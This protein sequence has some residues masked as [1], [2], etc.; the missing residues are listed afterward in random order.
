MLT[1]EQRAKLYSL[2]EGNTLKAKMGYHDYLVQH[3]FNEPAVE[4]DVRA[5]STADAALTSNN[6]QTTPEEFYRSLNQSRHP[7]MLTHYSVSDLAQMKLFKV[8]GHDIGYALKKWKDGSFSEIVAVHNNEPTVKGLGKALVRSSIRNGGCILDHFEGYLS[9]LY[10][11]MGFE[12]F[13]R[14]LFDPQYD[15]TGSFRAK[16]GP[17]DV[18]YRVLPR[19]K[20]KVAQ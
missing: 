10:S 8:P 11:S 14:D 5:A 16:Y 6:L 3:V 18:I 7:D 20:H 12:E 15:P 4:E 13:S 17:A 1:P 9:D 2:L 19:C